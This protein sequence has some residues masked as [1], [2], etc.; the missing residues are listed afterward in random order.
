[1]PAWFASLMMSWFMFAR[2]SART[3]MASAPQMSL[4]PL[5]PKRC[6]RRFISSEVPPV[7]VPSQPSIGWMAMRLP[8]VLPFTFART[9]GCERGLPEPASMA[10]SRGRSTPSAAQW[11]RKSATVLSDAT[12]VSLKGVDMA[13]FSGGC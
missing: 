12:R 4:A 6:Q 10:S 8:M 2:P 9:I 13:R 3:A 7:V 1:M 5:A 11:A